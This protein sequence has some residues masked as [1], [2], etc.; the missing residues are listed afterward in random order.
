LFNP[1]RGDVKLGQIRLLLEKANALSEKWDKI[2]IVLAG[3]FNSTPD[4]AIYKF[5]TT[6]KVEGGILPPVMN[7][8]CFRQA[9]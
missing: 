5:L 4:S 8:C 1:K 7:A 3:D 6:M 9:N 2:P